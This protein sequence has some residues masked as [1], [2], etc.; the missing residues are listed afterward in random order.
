MDNFGLGLT[1]NITCVTNIYRCI[2]ITTK[3]TK[4]SAPLKRIT[5]NLS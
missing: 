2:S 5:E 1:K 3:F 4:G